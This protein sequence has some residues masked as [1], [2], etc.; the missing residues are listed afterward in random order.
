MLGARAPLSTALKGTGFSSALSP[1]SSL[2]LGW[3]LWDTSCTND[4]FP[5]W[6]GG[7]LLQRRSR[8]WEMAACNC[9]HPTG[10]AEPL[11]ALFYRR[12]N[13]GSERWSPCPRPHVSLMWQGAPGAQVSDSESS[14]LS[15]VGGRDGESL[16]PWTLWSPQGLGPLVCPAGRPG[17]AVEEVETETGKRMVWQNQK[18]SGL[19]S[20]L[21]PV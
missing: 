2:Q 13:R 15:G 17:P 7:C 18:A 21:S 19:A 12:E 20:I 10:W 6:A 4:A 11:S 14:A 1:L 5:G 16:R 3:F 8:P 9:C